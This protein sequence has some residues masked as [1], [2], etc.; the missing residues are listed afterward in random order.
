MAMRTYKTCMLRLFKLLYTQDFVHLFLEAVMKQSMVVLVGFCLLS[1]LV[2][3]GANFS[4]YAFGYVPRQTEF[5]I[6]QNNVSL[7]TPTRS[8][9]SKSG[10]IEFT[11]PSKLKVTESKGVISIRH[12]VP[13]DH[14]DPCDL[15]RGKRRLK[16]IEDFDVEMRIVVF[17]DLR[18][19]KERITLG[20]H[21]DIVR[22]ESGVE[23]C[24]TVTYFIS[25]GTKIELAIKAYWVAEFSTTSEAVYRLV[26]DIIIPEEHEKILHEIIA[27]IRVK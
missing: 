11:Y 18:S 3:G 4:L 22:I 9:R 14:M 26:P 13:F 27:S 12:S 7:P 6:L 21:K 23:G 8:Y 15:A 10:A 17:P 5:R 2:A 16:N 1:I 20:T 24:G 25:V 19:T